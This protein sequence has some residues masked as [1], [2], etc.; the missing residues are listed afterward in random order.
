V[1]NA[2]QFSLRLDH[3]LSD[4]SQLM[5]R[6]NFNNLFGPTTNPDQTAIDPSFGVTYVDHQRNGIVTYTRTVSP[7]SHLAKLDQLHPHHAA[8]PTPNHTDPAVKFNDGLYEGFNTAGG[9]VM[10]AYGNL[11]QGQQNFT[12]NVGRHI[13]KAGAEARLNRD[14]T[15]FGISPN[16]EYDFGG[17]TAYSPVDIPSQSGKNNIAAGQAL[18]DTLSA[19]LTGRPFVYTVAVAP[20]YTSGG[21]HIGPAA[22]SRN[23]GGIYAQDTWKVSDRF[24]FD[25]GLRWEIYSPITERAKRTSGFL[26]VDPPAGQMQQYLDNP[27][28]GYKTNLDSFGPRVQVDWLVTPK[29]HAAGGITTIP[30]NIWQDNFL[31]GAVPFAIYPHLITSQSA[32]I[33]YGFQITSAELPNFY[34]T[35][36]KTSSP[37]GRPT[38]SPPTPSSILSATSA[39]WPRSL[40]ERS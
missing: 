34:N 16:G 3:R 24:T 25:Y 28:P 9:S 35:A 2:N 37:A 22:I 13:I 26:E 14:T 15:Y 11:F 7:R 4:K 39:I 40:P 33:N 29:L 6:F 30:P 20:P 36:G 27:Q 17:G 8:I 5:A 31:T 21:D 32:P 12:I 1:T 38:L 23:A 19:L 10:S 18:P